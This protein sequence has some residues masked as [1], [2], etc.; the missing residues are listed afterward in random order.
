MNPI[1]ENIQDIQ[2][3][4]EA[5]CQRSGRAVSSVRLI[6][7]TKTIDVE[8]INLAVQAG[9]TILG[10]N[11][12]QEVLSKYESV[13]PDVSWHLIG[14]LQTNKVR[15][16]IDHVTLIHSLDS[17]HLAH[18]LQ[19]RASQ[20]GKAVEVLIE[21]N[22]GQEA[23]KFG[24][25]PEDVP[26]FLESL[27][28]MNFIRVCG[29]MTVAPFLPDPEDVR[30]VFRRLKTLF[31]AM[32]HINQPNVTMEHLSMGMTHDF[33]VAVEEGATM[34]RVGTGIFGSRNYAVQEG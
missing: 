27:K 5:A 7:V 8:Q 15:Q 28:D 24:L 17:V 21:V 11:R 1:A 31:D 12:V 34:V 3:R 10:E 26:A 23:S 30:I 32:K 16:I 2:S 13:S 9:M 18:E 19:K 14:H 25:S 4:I 22:V 6:A 33:E 29:L 20:R